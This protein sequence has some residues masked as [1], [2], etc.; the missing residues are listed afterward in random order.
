MDEY[1]LVWYFHCVH[2]EVLLS[3]MCSVVYSS[4]STDDINGIDGIKSCFSAP[5]GKTGQGSC[6]HRA[7]WQAGASVVA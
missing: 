1:L 4:D 7:Q 6:S 3:C 2:I 5:P